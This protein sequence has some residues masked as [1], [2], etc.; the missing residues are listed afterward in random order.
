[1]SKNLK[2]CFYFSDSFAL[3]EILT[4]KLVPV[5]LYS[6]KWI[7]NGGIDELSTPVN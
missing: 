7:Q 1:M 6:C 4:K 3:Y 2:S 5:I